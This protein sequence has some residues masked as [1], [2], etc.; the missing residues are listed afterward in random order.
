MRVYTVH[1]THLNIPVEKHNMRVSALL[2]G[3]RS[4]LTV[5]VRPEEQQVVN[6][7]RVASG[8]GEQL[9]EPQPRAPRAYISAGCCVQPRRFRGCRRCH[10]G[11]RYGH[12]Y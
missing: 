2:L 5:C 8:H 11:H 7:A 3:F 1:R 12:S 10:R 6:S 9:L 4:S